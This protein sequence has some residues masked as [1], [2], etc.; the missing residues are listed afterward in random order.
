MKLLM[1]LSLQKH[2]YNVIFHN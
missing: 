2:K 1:K